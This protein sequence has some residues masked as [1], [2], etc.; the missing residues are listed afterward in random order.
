M[1]TVGCCLSGAVAVGAD[2]TAALLVFLLRDHI[3][4]KP[5]LGVVVA[6]AAVAAAVVKVVD[7]LVS[8]ARSLSAAAS[9]VPCD[10]HSLVSENTFI[11][12]C[13]KSTTIST[14]QHHAAVAITNSA[15]SCTAHRL[16]TWC[17]SGAQL[18]SIVQVR[19]ARTR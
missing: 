10:S 16:R 8:I 13:S 4:L 6:L 2:A 12:Q 17:M 3:M 1:G 9:S 7:V 19:N 14:M 18:L 15:C 11:K 5:P